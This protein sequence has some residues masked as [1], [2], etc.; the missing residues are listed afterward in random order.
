MCFRRWRDY[1]FPPLARQGTPHLHRDA[2][3]KALRAMGFES[4][5]APHGFRAMFRTL[6][7]ERLGIDSDI[8]EAQLA[9]AK[10]GEVQAA[11]DRTAFTEARREAMQQWADW[12]DGLAQGANMTSLRRLAASN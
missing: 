2:L 1:V 6:A 8:L 5:H 12:L 9:H 10:R 7:R 3:S 4:K 11:Y